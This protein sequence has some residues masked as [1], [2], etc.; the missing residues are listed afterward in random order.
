M[1]CRAISFLVM[2][3]ALILSACTTTPPAEKER[4]SK[5]GHGK[6]ISMAV[7]HKHGEAYSLYGIALGESRDSV[8]EK[9]KLV[10]C[11]KDV[12]FTRCAALLDTAEVQGVI[13]ADK[14]TLFI[15]FKES[16]VHNMSVLVP[17]STLDH[18]KLMLERMYGQAVIDGKTMS[19]RN[20][21]GRVVLEE[22][23]Q[24]GQSTSLTYEISA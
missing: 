21:S 6:A 23:A 20:E 15:A 19:W 13:N 14:T 8:E 4:P 16:G 11:R 2:V 22:D 5:V 10:A 7:P 12:F 18:T 1:T 17:S 9:Y 3:S 24:S